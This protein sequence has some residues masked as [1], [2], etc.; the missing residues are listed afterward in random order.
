MREV[1]GTK[2]SFVLTL[3]KD[4]AMAKRILGGKEC[5]LDGLFPEELDLYARKGKILI[6]YPGDRPW[7]A[8]ATV[9]CTKTYYE[10]RTTL[11]IS[12]TIID[13]RI[14][15]ADKRDL[16]AINYEL[17]VKEEED[18]ERQSLDEKRGKILG[19]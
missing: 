15:L 9:E 7:L 4:E 2:C 17:G 18:T 19:P 16:A 8:E 14:I 12:C 5:R 13:A 1:A 3:P 10:T 6:Y 11:A